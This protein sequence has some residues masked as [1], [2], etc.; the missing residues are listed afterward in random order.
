MMREAGYMVNYIIS[1]LCHAH[2]RQYHI[3]YSGYIRGYKY[4]CF[5]WIR[6]VPQTFITA[7]LI[8]HACMLQKK[9][10]THAS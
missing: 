4:S 2:A 9:A 3:L 1:C 8:F 6:H 7:N 5:S 10:V